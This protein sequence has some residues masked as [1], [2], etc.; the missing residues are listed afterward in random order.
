MSVLVVEV[1]AAVVD[2]T[3]LEAAVKAPAL[4]D[5]NSPS[6]HEDLGHIGDADLVARANDTGVP[7]ADALHNIQILQSQG[8][9]GVVNLL[10]RLDLVLAQVD[11]DLGDLF[12]LTDDNNSESL[13]IRGRDISS[14]ESG[15]F[16][17]GGLTQGD[18][19]ELDGLGV[20]VGA[21][22]LGR[23]WNLMNRELICKVSILELSSCLV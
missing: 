15:I 1:G 22:K 11:N 16:S 23:L 12:R 7:Q 6:I 17:L 10:V 18:A 2:K 14:L 21:D 8:G 19:V 4:V 13:P 3:L 5:T 20:A 9:H